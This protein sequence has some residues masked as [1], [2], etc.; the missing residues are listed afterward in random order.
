MLLVD[1]VPQSH[2]DLNDPR[3][4][5]LEYVR[6]LG[7]VVDLVAASG[8]P[9]RVLHLG[10]GGLSLA[11]YLS[12][13]RPG[14]YQLGIESDRE[15]AELVQRR[16]PAD[17]IEVRLADARA[18]L[19]LLPARSFDVVVA[20]AFNGAQT[21]AHLTSAEFV[22]AAANSL[23]TSGWFAANVSD[24]P[25]LAHARGRIA[26]VRSVFSRTCV[27]AED[28]VLRG[29]NFG[30]LV[31]VGTDQ[32][33]PLKELSNR[34]AADPVPARVLAGAA[35]DRLLAGAVPISDAT[36]QPSQLPQSATGPSVVQ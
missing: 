27:I 32:D 21:P 7:H 2:V 1:D 14:S 8:T 26:A 19:S 30:N 36:A 24:G 11:R 25:P 18:V 23:T 4:L 35:L 20:D 3:H 10:A 6:R 29:L 5:E 33:L 31:V 12:A 13:T 16:L 17:H 15:V 22:A 28:E 9:L 34:C